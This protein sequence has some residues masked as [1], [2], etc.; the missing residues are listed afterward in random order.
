MCF[1][2][3]FFFSLSLDIEFLKYMYT[4]V[5]AVEEINRDDSLLPGV[6]LGYRI[7]DSCSRYPWALDGALSL[8]TGDS[9]SCNVAASSTRTNTGAVGGKGWLET[10]E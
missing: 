7:R 1:S 2:F 6:R 3:F 9:N 10:K 8:V 5:F 4:M